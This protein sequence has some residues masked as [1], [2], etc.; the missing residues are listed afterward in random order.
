MVC[1][2]PKYVGYFKRHIDLCL[3][4]LLILG[5]YLPIFLIVTVLVGK[6]PRGGRS[7]SSMFPIFFPKIAFIPQ[8]T[9][10]PF[11]GF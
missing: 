11:H 10:P 6:R 3:L 8:P 7:V 2:P 1:S 5:A 9:S 4:T